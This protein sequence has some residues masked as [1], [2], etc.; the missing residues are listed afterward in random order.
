MA[1]KLNSINSSVI[2]FNEVW[3]MKQWNIYLN[4]R[5][6]D[7]VFFQYILDR[8][9]VYDSLVNHDGY[10]SRIIVRCARFGL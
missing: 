7:S 6:I 4:N 10:D 3:I 8:H 5:I 1:I 2:N 9:Y